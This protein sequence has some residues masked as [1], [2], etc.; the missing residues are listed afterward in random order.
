MENNKKQNKRKMGSVYEK[1][2]G[3]ILESQGYTILEYNYHC[4]YGEADI[5]AKEGDCL[6]F[7][8]VKYRKNGHRG[9]PL[10][11]VGAEKQKRIITCARFYIME[12][13]LGTL[14]LRFDVIGIEGSMITHVRNA[15]YG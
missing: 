5:I 10:E 7:C 2:V 4:R 12:H 14:P 9:N 8:E 15:F 13:H 6:V 1:A 11:A 3:G